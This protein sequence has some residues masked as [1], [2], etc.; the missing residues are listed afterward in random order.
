WSIGYMLPNSPGTVHPED[1]LREG[2]QAVP[3]MADQPGQARNAAAA[4]AARE[5]K[6][7]ESTI[8]HIHGAHGLMSGRGRGGPGGGPLS[9]SPYMTAPQMPTSNAGTNRNG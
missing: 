6:T 9:P 4:T 2:I 5:T 8:T 7:T 3:G 1:N